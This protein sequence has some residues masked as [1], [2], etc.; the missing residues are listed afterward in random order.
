MINDIFQPVAQTSLMRG[1]WR[2]HNTGDLS[3][4]GDVVN[5]FDLNGRVAIVTGGNGGIGLGIAKG[6]VGAGAAV[7]ITGR[8]RDKNARALDTLSALGSAT[9]VECDVSVA[10]DLEAL[11]AEVEQRHG[12]L[13]V[14]VNNAGMSGGG[15]PEELDIALWNRILAVNL[16]ATLET[17]QRAF[18]YFRAAGG[19]KIINIA[20]EYALFG[21]AYVAPYA[22]S[23]GGLIQLTRSLAV[24]WAPHG[25]QVNAITPGWITTEMTA[26]VQRN[27]AFYDQIIARTPAGRFGEPDELAGAAVFLASR[28]S[29]FV[30]G[31]NL[32]VDGGYASA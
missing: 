1:A 26:P 16:T 10:S 23:K 19:G 15:R 29:D 13:D 12:R 4:R 32:P 30:T 27:R 24:A 2:G 20:S 17:S 5:A 25:I 18:P 31:I 11:F 21:S 28:A 22:A 8:N 3:T 14:L 9:C 7:V 6:L